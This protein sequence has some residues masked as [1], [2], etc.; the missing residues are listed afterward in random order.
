M[1]KAPFT[2]I[3]CHIIHGIGIIDVFPWLGRRH[4]SF[5]TLHKNCIGFFCSG[6]CIG[7]KESPWVNR[8]HAQLIGSF[9]LGDGN[10]WKKGRSICKKHCLLNFGK[11]DGNKF[12]FI[13]NLKHK[14]I[15]S[16]LNKTVTVE[17]AFKVPMTSFFSFLLLIYT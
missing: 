6:F 14:W 4:L 12:S 5:I 3:L 11:T 15:N 16:N 9:I 17:I 13:L 2:K 7:I 8:D 10:P 1:F